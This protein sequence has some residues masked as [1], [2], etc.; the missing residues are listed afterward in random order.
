MPLL[1][2]YQPSSL[3]FSITDMWRPC[4]RVIFNLYPLFKLSFLT[5]VG[6]QGTAGLVGLPPLGPGGS[7][8]WEAAAACPTGGGGG[9]AR[10]AAPR[11]RGPTTTVVCQVARLGGARRR[12]PHRWAK[13][14]GWPCGR[15]WRPRPS[16]PPSFAQSRAW[17]ELAAR[18]Q[19][20]DEAH[21]GLAAAAFPP[22]PSPLGRIHREQ[23]D[24]KL[25]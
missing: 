9:R 18:R 1:L 10:R 3:L 17:P 11:P 21:Q 15:S 6:E 20:L 19:G 13:L 24:A 25:L 7:A 4:V 22:P 23:I 12:L 8:C 5:G 2:S 16:Q 14:V